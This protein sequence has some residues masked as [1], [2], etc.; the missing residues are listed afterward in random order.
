[1][2]CIILAIP[3][4]T[5][6]QTNC[7][8]NIFLAVCFFGVFSGGFCGPQLTLISSLFPTN[9]RYSA[10]SF[11]YCIGL[12]TVGG[13]FPLIATFLIQKTNSLL[14]P[15]FY[16]IVC[17]ILGFFSVIISKRYQISEA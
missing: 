10:A 7:I 1:M 5:L 13:T 6:M 11:C 12:M 16:I 9:I 14:S 15:A 4:F 3:A 8:I 2:F 17:A